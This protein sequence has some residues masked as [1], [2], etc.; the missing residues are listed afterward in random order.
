MEVGS[1]VFTKGSFRLHIKLVACAG[2]A[3]SSM[4]GMGTLWLPNRLLAWWVLLH[5]DPGNQQQLPWYQLKCNT[6]RGQGL[7]QF[8]PGYLRLFHISYLCVDGL[9]N[10]VCVLFSCLSVW[11]VGVWFCFVVLS[12]GA[13]HVQQHVCFH[14]KTPSVAVHLLFT[15]CV[16]VCKGFGSTHLLCLLLPKTLFSNPTSLSCLHWEPILISNL[17]IE[18]ESRI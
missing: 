5:G 12:W 8:F 4:D 18:V 7:L 16:F 3:G 11:R 10:L 13:L 6:A 14:G 15:L 1:L 17:L 9:P 2:H